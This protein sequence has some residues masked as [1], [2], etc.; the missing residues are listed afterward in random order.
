M[1]EMIIMPKTGMAMEEGTIVEWLKKEGDH[2]EKGEVIAEIE[3]DKSTMEL[4][5]D[6]DGYLL[7]IL[8]KDGTTVPVTQPIAWLGKEGEQIPAIDDFL[9]SISVSEGSSHLENPVLQENSAVLNTDSDSIRITPAARRAASEQNVNLIQLSPTGNQGEIRKRDVMAFVQVRTTLK[10]DTIIKNQGVNP[11]ESIATIENVTR[12]P[13]TTIQRIT[14][15]RMLEST[16]FIPMV[17]EQIKVDVTRLLAFRQELNEAIEQKITINDLVLFAVGK[18]LKAHPRLNSIFD[19]DA[20]LYKSDINI[21]MA[22]ASPAGLIV[23]VIRC[24]DTYKLKELSKKAEELS[25][26]ARAG[27]QKPEDMYGATFTVSNVGMYG[28]T[29]FTPIINP[30]EAAILGV[31]A[32]EGLPRFVKGLLE[33]RKIMGLNLTFDHRVV[34]G[35]ESAFFLKYLKDLLESYVVLFA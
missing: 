16:Q 23:P 19:G 3:T 8:Y 1:A 5:S 4:E 18:A 21:G 7:K 13:L 29:A 20:L 28:I 27:E 17:T 2:V 31:C 10:K 32:V 15:K 11:A 34:D 14:G 25:S 26:L 24:A 9:E 33:E 30:P 6:Y 22:V 35:V 12:V